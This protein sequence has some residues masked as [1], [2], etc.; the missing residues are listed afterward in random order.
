MLSVAQMLSDISA[1]TQ[2]QDM[3]LEELSK[4]LDELKEQADKINDEVGVKPDR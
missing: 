2:E 4:G 3:I 1:Q